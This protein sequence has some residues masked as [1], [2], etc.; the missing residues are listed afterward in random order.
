MSPKRDPQFDPNMLTFFQLTGTPVHQNR[1]SP[2][3]MALNLLR[4]S[5]PPMHARWSGP[6]G[7]RL[8]F[9]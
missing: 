5:Q 9:R 8:Q 1:G 2:A 6:S 3:R 4:N 7:H